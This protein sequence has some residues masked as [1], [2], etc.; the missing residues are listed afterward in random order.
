MALILPVLG[1]I[2]IWDIVQVRIPNTLVFLGLALS[3]IVHGNSGMEP[4]IYSL[5]GCLV[6]FLAVLPFYSMGLMGGGDVKLS[7]LIGAA[8]QFPYVVIAI[9]LGLAGAAII[10]TLLSA[11]GIGKGDSSYPMA[12]MFVT[13]GILSLYLGDDLISSFI[14]VFS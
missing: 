11:L 5:V 12:P 3:F 13:G 14:S 1:I 4:L 2:F 6:G 8:V 9:L 10:Y 7:A